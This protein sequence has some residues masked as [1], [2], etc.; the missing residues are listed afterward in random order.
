MRKLFAA[1]LAMILCAGCTTPYQ[2]LGLLG[3]VRAQ[4]VTADT[5]RIVSRGNSHT[6]STTIRDYTLL[7]AAETTKQSGA[8][9]FAIISE[10]DVTRTSQDVTLQRDDVMGGVTGSISTDVKPGQDTYIRVMSIAPGQPAPAGALSA[11]EIMRYV[12]SRVK[13]PA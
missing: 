7:K 9:H 3:G 10:K 1:G 4:Q 2:E 6:S 13:R 12:G 5:Y 11:D 8:T